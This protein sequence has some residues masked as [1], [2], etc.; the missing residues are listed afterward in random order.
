MTNQQRQ[1]IIQIYNHLDN[2]LRESLINDIVR[3]EGQFPIISIGT[4]NSRN[5]PLNYFNIKHQEIYSPVIF[6]GAE[7]TRNHIAVIR[8][9]ARNVRQHNI[10]ERNFLGFDLI[11]SEDWKYVIVNQETI[12]SLY[13]LMHDEC[14]N[15]NA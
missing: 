7:K 1:D 9:R 4:R 15:F 2:R 10:H 6:A 14:Q 5:Q 8:F 13:N 3:A 12:S 11:R